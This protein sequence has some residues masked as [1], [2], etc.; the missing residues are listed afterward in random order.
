MIRN[1]RK[2]VL[3][4]RYHVAGKSVECPHCGGV[5][6]VAGEAQLNTALASLIDLDWA[7]KTAAT[8]TCITCG[9]IQWF[10]GAPTRDF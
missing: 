8:L 10:A 6:F 4:G 3:P 5:D 1:S 9:R 7:N 2:Q